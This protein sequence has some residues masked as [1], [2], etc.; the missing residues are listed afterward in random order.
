MELGLY[1]AMFAHCVE[2][3]LNVFSGNDHV[4]IRVIIAWDKPAKTELGLAIE[5]KGCGP[6]LLVSCFQELFNLLGKLKCS[7]CSYEFLI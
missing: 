5:Y 1:K 6:L 2:R 7:V 3:K 4:Y